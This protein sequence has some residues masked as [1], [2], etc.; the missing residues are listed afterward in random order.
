MTTRERRERRA[1]Q[2]EEWAASRAAKSTAAYAKVKAIGDMIPMGQPILVGHHSEGRHRRDADRIDSGMRASID[3]DRMADRHA[4]AA[5]EIRA[6]LDVSIY[7]DDPDAIERLTEKLA[8]LEAER[9]RIK[10]F[11]AAVRKAKKVTPDATAHLD[12]AQRADLASTAKACPAFLGSYGQFPSYV[13][14]NL[15]GNIKRT[16][17]RIA[18]LERQAARAEQGLPTRVIFAR[19]DGRCP[20]CHGPITAGE[21]IGKFDDEWR[22]EKCPEGEQT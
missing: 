9:A 21:R 22:H 5:A 6:Q 8:G 19:R 16:R 1:E 2:R 11:N 14:S 3:H 18:L 17:D 10:A 20:A 13:L 7:S 15:S 12:D 4:S